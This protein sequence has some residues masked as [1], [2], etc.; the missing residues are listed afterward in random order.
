MQI[1][2]PEI[3][4][5][6]TF[7]WK[8]STFEQPWEKVCLKKGQN[9]KRHS[10]QR[11]CQ[12]KPGAFVFT[13]G[14]KELKITQIVQLNKLFQLLHLVRIYGHGFNEL[15]RMVI[16]K[17]VNNDVSKDSPIGVRF[18]EVLVERDLTVSQG[19]DPEFYSWIK[20]KKGEIDVLPNL[21]WNANLLE[22]S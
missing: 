11:N 2:L 21:Q 14:C 5:Y 4:M 20:Q 17:N 15:S 13:I 8:V 6:L 22:V 12:Q 1:T 9:G 7:I 3:G 19:L 10:H 16:R 18:R